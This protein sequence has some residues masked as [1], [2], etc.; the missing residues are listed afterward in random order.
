[1][2]V[3][4]LNRIGRENFPV[5]RIVLADKRKSAKGKHLE[6]LGTYN[7]A[8]GKKITFKKDRIEY[9]VSKGAQPSDTV[10]SLLKM[11]GVTNME[12]FIGPRHFK[13]K[14]KNEE[15]VVE[16]PVQAAA[17]PAPVEEAAPA[18]EPTPE[19]EV[20]AEAP[21]KEEAPAETVAEAP[22]EEAKTEEPT[23]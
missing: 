15:E 22:A 5:Y 11:N 17:A 1:M 18:A 10:A 14:K 20:V 12:K 7:V 19:P 3:L 2:L 8:D 16:A 6:V 13:R 9:W 4:R 23:A 21:A